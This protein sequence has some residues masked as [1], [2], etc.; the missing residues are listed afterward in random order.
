MALSLYLILYL[1]LS[2]MQVYIIY[3]QNMIQEVIDSKLKKYIHAVLM[4]HP[5]CHSPVKM[6]KPAIWN[7][8]IMEPWLVARVIL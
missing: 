8:S 3:S 1:V 5:H 7:W 2:I 6:M 4:I